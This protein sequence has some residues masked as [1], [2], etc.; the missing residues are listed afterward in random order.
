VKR[1]TKL[2][3]YRCYGCIYFDEDSAA[4]GV[5]WA[6][7]TNKQAFAEFLRQYWEDNGFK[8][9]R[10]WMIPGWMAWFMD[11]FGAFKEGNQEL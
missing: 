3:S 9:M 5:V 7:E 1:I 4:T 10:Y 8:R 6:W 11:D 2:F